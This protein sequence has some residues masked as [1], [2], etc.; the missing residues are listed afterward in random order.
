M[1]NE[2][3]E[4]LPLYQLVTMPGCFYEGSW[5]KG[6]QHGKGRIFTTNGVYFEGVFTHGI[7]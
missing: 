3:S 1:D 6:K 2:G 4:E 7:A 5:K